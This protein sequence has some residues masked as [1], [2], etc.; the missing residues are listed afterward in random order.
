M[1]KHR[2]FTTGNVE[3]SRAQTHRSATGNLEHKVRLVAALEH[4]GHLTAS[5]TEH[6]D[7]LTRIFARNIDRCFFDRLEQIALII[8]L[9][10]HARTPNL[11]FKAFSA[12]RFHQD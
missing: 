1:M 11:E 4:V 12:H 3:Q 5:G 2:C 10:D 6:L 8:L 7:A 9:D